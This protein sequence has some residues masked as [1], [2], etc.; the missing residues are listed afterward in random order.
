MKITKIKINNFNFHKNIEFDI[1]GN[2]LIYGEN[3]VGKSSI[4]L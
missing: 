2:L 4:F 1:N 3:G